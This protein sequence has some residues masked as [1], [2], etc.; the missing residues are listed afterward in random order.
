M[1]LKSIKEVDVKDKIVFLRAD[2]DVPIENGKML[3]IQD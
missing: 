2:L 3:M 1:K